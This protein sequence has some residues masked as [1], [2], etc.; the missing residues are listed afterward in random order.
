MEQPTR[1]LHVQVTQIDYTLAQSGPLDNTSLPKAPVIRVYGAS[2]L[3]KK[4]CLHIHQVYPYFFVEYPGQTNPTAVSRYIARL[5]HALN[6]AIAV[7]L[8]RNPQSSKSRFVRAVVLVK[9]V[10]FYGFHSSYAP[11]LKI[12]IVDPAFLNRAVTIMQ[13][14]SVMATRFHTFE[15][16]L[17]FILQFLCDFGLYG[18]GGLE[19][20]RAWVRGREDN[21]EDEENESGLELSSYFRQTRMPLEIDSIAPFI[22]NRHRLTA[23]HLHHKLAIPAPILP[24]EP[25]VLGV[26]ELWDDER[27]RRTA[28]GLSPSPDIP[29]DPSEKSRG[30]GGEWVAEA[31]WWDEI[32][33]RIEKEHEQTTEVKEDAW[34]KWI[35]TTFESVEA[36]WEHRFRTFGKKAPSSHD[37]TEH[38]SLNPYEDV[39]GTARA[40][41]APVEVDE[42][43]LS[44][45]ELSVLL[46]EEE[47]EWAKQHGQE[48]EEGFEDRADQEQ[49]QAEEGPA[50]DLHL[51]AHSSTSRRRE[52]ASQSVQKTP[53]KRPNAFQE[54]FLKL[55]G[56]KSSMRSRSHSLYMSS[57]MEN[58]GLAS[59]ERTP[60]HWTDAEQMEIQ[61]EHQ[62]LQKSLA[63]AKSA[64]FVSIWVLLCQLDA[65]H[66][67]RLVSQRDES[68]SPS[69]YGD[70]IGHGG[71][72]ELSIEESHSTALHA[73]EPFELSTVTRIDNGEVR[74]LKRLRLASPPSAPDADISALSHSVSRHAMSTQAPQAFSAFAKKAMKNAYQYALR[75]PSV[76]EVTSTFGDY[77]VP[78][79]IYRA[80]YYSVEADAPDRAW[81]F[82]GL[83]YHLKGGSGLKVLEDWNAEG[84]GERNKADGNDEL[85]VFLDRLSSRGVGGWEYASAPPSTREV[86]KWLKSNKEPKH[87]RRKTNR[88]ARSQALLIDGPTQLHPYGLKDTPPTH[89]DATIREKQSMS[90]MSLE[91]FAPSQGSLLPDP[92]VDPI[93]VV[94]YTFQDSELGDDG[95]PLKTGII[96]VESTYLNDGRLRTFSHES[97]TDELELLNRVVDTILDLDPDVLAGW[98]IQSASWGYLSA[99]GRQYGFDI[100]EQI[101]RAPGRSASGG[102]EQWGQRTTSTFHAIGRHALNV[103]RIMRV[104]QSLNNYT[105]ENTVFHL[106]QRSRVPRYTPAT[107]TEWYYSEVPAH[108]VR[109]LQHLLNRTTMVLEML[110]AAETITKTAEFARVFGVDFFSVIS[111]GSQFKVESFMFRIAKPES[112]VLLSPSR[113]DVGSQNAAE[114]MPLIMEP[115]S[116][117]YS[118]PLVVLD[119]QSLYPSIMVAYNYCYS[120]C[121]GRVTPF[122]GQYKF[123]VTELSHPPGLLDTLKDHITVAPNGMM[124][125]KSEVRKGLLGRMLTELL[126]TRVMVKQAM[127]GVKGNK[128]LRRILDARQLGL[129]YIA[130]VTYGYTSATFSGRMPAV[131]IA[132]SIVQSGRETLEKAVRLIES[133]NK[134]GAKVVY[135]DTDSLF[136]YLLGKTKEQA[137][138]IGH[139]IADTVTKLNPAPVKLK[140][141]KVYLPC[142]LMAKKRYVGFKY[143]NPDDTEPV[144][145]AKGIETVRRDGVP[146]QQKMTETALKMLFRSQDLSEVKEYCYRSWSKILENKVSIQDFIFAR[147]VKMGTYSDK[148]PPPPGVTVAA[149][150]MLRDPNDEPQYGERIPYVIVRGPPNTRLVDRAVAPEELLDAGHEHLDGTYYISRVLIPPLERVFNLVGADV[151]A[152]CDEMPKR[153]RSDQVDAVLMSPKKGAVEASAMDRPKIEEHFRNFQCFTCG[154]FTA[155]GVCDNCCLTPQE[156]IAQLLSR[157]RIAEKRLRETHEVC[158]TCTRAEP[159]EPILCES[160]DCGWLFARKKAEA[161]AEEIELL[162]ELVEEVTEGRVLRGP[163]S[164][165]SDWSSEASE[166]DRTWGGIEPGESRAMT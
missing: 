16:H 117:F 55:A 142:V 121:L 107:L 136:I 3:G 91:V 76:A 36:L 24:P 125:V 49:D 129:K 103:W 84:E 128:A 85:N 45:Q 66:Q 46:E 102:T 32:R 41:E 29:K 12:Y 88:P 86:R 28:A 114:C 27:R 155:D 113:Q 145:D 95:P 87:L 1:P 101:S 82:A 70:T 47:M 111:R 93:T 35:M 132:D 105:F 9:G 38:P 149:R 94:F 161:N 8:K 112:F 54:A 40:D 5:S 50:L 104:E 148:V 62:T 63:A 98:E 68:S 65:H 60:R 69:L 127:K 19:L 81:E 23:R 165:T 64:S 166:D 67:L 52:T 164:S 74:P 15:S 138:R 119:F 22:L 150:R 89:A 80:P 151:R 77:G 61:R 79:K 162:S 123:G 30:A 96:A 109:L 2:S 17:S 130:N 75:P 152:W 135:G 44:S 99:R 147:E 120:T 137:F 13:S 100:G 131:E 115:L 37:A 48:V 146:A 163:E 14:G 7:S 11:F 51:D 56:Y 118:S 126:D 78:D 116:A 33:S 90:V 53:L 39:S 110:D 160:L 144:F 34:A 157:I 73:D 106:L 18:C 26:R 154:G 143:E 158:G 71:L 124:Y 97:V 108:G 10:H 140:F 42:S 83:M 57:S 6:Y 153:I 25:L 122:K 156:T 31:R 58:D 159:L 43:M 141:E 4:C 133:T 134:W 21:P 139:D 92:G 20:S 72:A 59:G